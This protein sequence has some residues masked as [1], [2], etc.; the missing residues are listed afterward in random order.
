MSVLFDKTTPDYLVNANAIV[1]AAPWTMAIWFKAGDVTGDSKWLMAVHADGTGE[2]LFGMLLL[3]DELAGSLKTD[4]LSYEVATST[5]SADTWY[6]GCF[7]ADS[8]SSRSI[9]LDG[10]SKATNTDDKTPAGMDVTDVGFLDPGTPGEFFDGE[11]AYATIWDVA[12]TD[13]EILSLARGT[14]PFRVRPLS[15]KA[16]WPLHGINTTHR[17]LSNNN[18]NLTETG[19]PVRGSTN[20]PVQSLSDVY[21]SY[22]SNPIYTTGAPPATKLR[23]LT[24]TGVG[25]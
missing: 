8:S 24:L 10:G 4:S 5:I 16:F 11:L 15:I 2:N 3:D 18:Y 14:F 23:T 1:S 22:A 6:H 19:S 17:D 13:T 12:L 9:Y 25:R 21:M 7:K 20:P